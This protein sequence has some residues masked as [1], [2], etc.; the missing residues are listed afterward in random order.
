AIAPLL[1]FVGPR[2]GWLSVGGVGTF[3]NHKRGSLLLF[4]LLSTA[5][6]LHDLIGAATRL[7]FRVLSTLTM[8]SVLAVVLT[9]GWTRWI[10]LT[11]LFDRPDNEYLA[12]CRWAC[13]H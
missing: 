7:R 10:G 3:I 13:D 2:L 12:L 6:A 5:P 9:I 1:I 4:C 8:I 11:V